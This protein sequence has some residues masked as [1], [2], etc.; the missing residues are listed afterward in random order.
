M[1]EF[2]QTYVCNYTILHAES[3]LFIWFRHIAFDFVTLTLVWEQGGLSRKCILE[4]HNAPQF[5]LGHVIDNGHSI[6]TMMKTLPKSNAL[7]YEHNTSTICARIDGVDAFDVAWLNKH[8]WRKKNRMPFV[9]YMTQVKLWCVLSQKR[10][11]VHNGCPDSKPVKGWRNQLRYAEIKLKS[12][13]SA[14]KKVFI[15][16]TSA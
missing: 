8:I 6:L 12:V 11:L 13:D 1:S 15:K 10:A 5:D 14:C 9:D 7:Q 2:R 16:H 4:W 3:T